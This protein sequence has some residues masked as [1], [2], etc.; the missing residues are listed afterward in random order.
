[1]KLRLHNHYHH[2]YCH[3]N[4][5]K[6]RLWRW[7]WWRRRNKQQYQHVPSTGFN[8]L[9]RINSFVN[10]IARQ[11]YLRVNNMPVISPGFISLFSHLFTIGWMRF[12]YLNVFFFLH[13]IVL[14]SLSTK[15]NG[16]NNTTKTCTHF[17]STSLSGYF[18]NFIVRFHL[19]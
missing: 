1:M 16:R 14:S 6:W 2:R 7:R 18:C 19:S 5:Q 12:Q 13:S 9:T 4:D 11:Y 10:G 15:Q 17:K 8:L 3:Y